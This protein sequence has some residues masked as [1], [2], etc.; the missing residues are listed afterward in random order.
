MVNI[1]TVEKGL[2]VVDVAVNE[3]C[4]ALVAKCTEITESAEWTTRF[5]ANEAL[6][7]KLAL[8]FNVPV[9]AVPDIALVFDVLRAAKV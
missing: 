4:P 9:A 1:W 7:Q 6:I 5:N 2:D 8:A 3:A